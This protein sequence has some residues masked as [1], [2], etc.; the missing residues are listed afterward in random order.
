[1]SQFLPVTIAGPTGDAVSA[2]N[3]LP[4]T[5]SGGSGSAS[6]ATAQVSVAATATSVVAAR[7]GR[8][9]VT[10]TNLGAT[11]VYLGVTGIT[12]ATGT[13]LPGVRGANIT[14]PTSAAVF[15]IAAT[16][17]QSVSVLETF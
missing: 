9:A 13:L 15:G 10:I 8:A 2:S 6:I 17:T 3:P 12:T 7:T 16:G 11:D 5:A 1:M 14:I 4:V